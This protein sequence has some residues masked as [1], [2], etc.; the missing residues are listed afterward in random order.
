MPLLFATGAGAEA[1]LR[2]E[3]RSVRYGTEY[4]ARGLY[5]NFYE[6]MQKLQEKFG[7]KQ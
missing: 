3:P 2:W 6:L 4:L 7:K 5:S 1:V